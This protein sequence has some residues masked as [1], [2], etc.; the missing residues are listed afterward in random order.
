MA[1]L[2]AGS[3]ERLD[4]L[5]AR[6]DQD[7][8]AHGD[9]LRA[10]T[11]RVDE[12]HAG[13]DAEAAERRSEEAERA[14][15]LAELSR[16][17]TQ[18]SERL[19]RMAERALRAEQVDRERFDAVEHRVQEAAASMSEGAEAVAAVEALRGRLEAGLDE[20]RKSAY[21][22]V[23]ELGRRLSDRLVDLETGADDQENELA[24][25]LELQSA[26]DSGMGELRSAVADLA[27]AIRPSAVAGA[28]QEPSGRPDGLA[29]AVPSDAAGG[30]G[31]G[32]R[33][34]GRSSAEASS[35]LAAV[36]AVADDVA[37]RQEQLEATV[38]ALEGDAARAVEA[39]AA[40][41]SQASS[42]APVRGDVRALR[43]QLAAQAEVLT[44]L[45]ESMAALARPA[46]TRKA[47][48]PRA[49][50]KPATVTVRSAKAS[51]A[52]STPSKG[53]TARAAI[54]KA[55]AAKAA[56]GTR[57]T[58]SAKKEA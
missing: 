52:R 47:A 49:V 54:A 41:S 33:L 50:A 38:A 12:L 58:R 15:V 4:D 2:E 8:A 46:P 42:L 57:P 26:L 30:R 18:L 36:A 10:L 55:A 24:R 16:V 31:R 20:A 29:A 35:Q 45:T 43:E 32:R 51:A 17:E 27:D 7:T 56:P 11:A 48:A 37:R 14:V 5:A 25:L 3:V 39:A 6:V 40:A 19:E 22:A 21:A 13:L 9:G 34:A 28:R 23:A 44:D 53:E 1:R